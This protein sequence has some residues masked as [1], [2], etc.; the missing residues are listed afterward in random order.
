MPT[1]KYIIPGF[2]NAWQVSCTILER[3]DDR[4]LIEYY[5]EAAEDWTVVL[6]TRQHLVFPKFSELII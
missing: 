1:V 2:R 3:Y 6:T 4:Y 5:D